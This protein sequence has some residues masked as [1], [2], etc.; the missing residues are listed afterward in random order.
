MQRAIRRLVLHGI[1]P[2]DRST[3]DGRL[4]ARQRAHRQARDGQSSSDAISAPTP[5]ASRHPK[6]MRSTSTA[7]TREAEARARNRRPGRLDRAQTATG[8]ARRGRRNFELALHS[9]PSSPFAGSPGAQEG[10]VGFAIVVNLGLVDHL[11]Q[12]LDLVPLFAVPTPLAHARERTSSCSAR[13]AC[14]AARKL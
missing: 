2:D 7:P 4:T 6:L 5:P 11:D 13:R 3:L 10:V 1:E 8:V 12:L 9:D 14:G